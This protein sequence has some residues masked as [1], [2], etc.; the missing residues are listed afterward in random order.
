MHVDNT[1]SFIQGDPPKPGEGAL[2]HHCGDY[3]LKQMKQ[4]IMNKLERRN[5]TVKFE[6][7]K[8]HQDNEKNRTKDKKGNLIPLTQPALLNIDCDERA[9][10]QYSEDDTPQSRVMPHSSIQIYFESN[11]IINTAKLLQQIITDRHGPKMKQYILTKFDWSSE[12]FDSVDWESAQAAYKQKTFNQKTRISKAIY[13]WLPTMGRLH[14]ISPDEYPSP[15]CNTC[16]NAIET[17]DHIFTCV[18]HAARTQQINAL[19]R[20]ES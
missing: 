9:E 18:H 13:R 17:Q 5:I 8:A 20:I 4:C 3:N 1:S 15:L 12:I 6:H 10:D 16:N 7:V 2:R 11:Q 14:T 19:K